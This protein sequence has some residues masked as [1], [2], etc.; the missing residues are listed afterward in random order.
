[1]D[2]IVIFGVVLLNAIIGFFQEGKAE[3]AMEAIRDM[4]SHQSTVLRDG[5]RISLP[6]EQLVPG[7]I[8]FLVSGDRVPADVRLFNVKNLRVDEASLTG[9]SVP[10][11]K[12][13]NPVEEKA[14]IG[15]RTSMAFSG[16]LVT[17][18]QSHGVVVGTGDDTELGRISALIALA[19]P[20]TTRLLLKMAEFGQKLTIAIGGLAALTFA[21]GVLIRG[22]NITEMF[23][24]AVGLAVAAI[25]EGLPAI[26]TITLAIGVQRMAG[27]NAIIRRLPSVETL[28]S[29]TVICSDKT[30]T[31][32]RNE[33]T[34]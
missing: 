33:M 15:D 19:P 26:L 31:L 27:R 18:G 20:M 23:L 9:E 10:V 13:V 4:L 22:Y 32:T 24:A 34:V 21:F 3:R 28:G 11:E 8:I 14:T 29:V 2:A 5:N 12:S 25:P 17:Y 6:S 1:V 16:T 7:D 30:G